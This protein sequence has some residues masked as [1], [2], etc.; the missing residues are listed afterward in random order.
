M[1]VRTD[2]ALCEHVWFSEFMCDIVRDAGKKSEIYIYFNVWSS[3]VLLPCIL[4]Y[5]WV[6]EYFFWSLQYCSVFEERSGV[7][8]FFFE[9]HATFFEGFFNSL[10]AGTQERRNAPSKKIWGTLFQERIDRG[11]RKAGMCPAVLKGENERSVLRKNW[12][13]HGFLCLNSICEN[14]HEPEMPLY[15]YI[16]Q[17]DLTTLASGK[18]MVVNIISWKHIVI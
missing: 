15:H 12:K 3:D 17:W 9:E 14:G 11:R 16:I 7:F 13:P 6:A 5:F 2:H 18:A 8:F 4:F 1:A 10:Q